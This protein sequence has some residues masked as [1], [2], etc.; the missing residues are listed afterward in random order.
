MIS[1]ALLTFLTTWIISNTEFNQEVELPQFFQLS[2]KEMSDKACY[3]S[4]NCR[5]KAYYIKNE[6]IFYRDNLVPDDNICHLSIILHEMVHHYQKNSNRTFDLDERT[7]W[8][9]QERQALYYQNLF[10]IS[11][12]R[13]NND[14]GPENILQCEGGSYLD[15]QYKYKETNQ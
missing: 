13:L 6:G 5:V 10:L 12:K 1:K 3:S 11:Q 9:L 15:L 14:K 7:L 8:T 2:K 4:A